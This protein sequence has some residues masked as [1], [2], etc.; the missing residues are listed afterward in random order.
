MF[1]KCIDDMHKV[2]LDARFSKIIANGCELIGLLILYF[3]F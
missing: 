3:V 2:S 1:Y